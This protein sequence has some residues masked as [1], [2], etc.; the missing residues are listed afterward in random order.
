[1]SAPN[2]EMLR[3][4]A[5]TSEFRPQIERMTAE[6]SE[7]IGR[8]EAALATLYE[9]QSALILALRE[10]VSAQIKSPEAGS[11]ASLGGCRP[12]NPSTGP[13]PRDNRAS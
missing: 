1:M 8:T 3:R 6:A 4:A 10:P 11:G 2:L 5:R 7:Q 9:Y 12:G 13:A